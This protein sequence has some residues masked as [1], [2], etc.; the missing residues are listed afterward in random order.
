MTT[1]LV[2]TRVKPTSAGA[3]PTKPPLPLEVVSSAPAPDATDV[4]TDAPISVTF[5]VPLAT[6]TPVPSLSPSVPGSWVQT[7]ADVLAF[8]ASAPLPPGASV[9]LTVPGGSQGVRGARGQLLDQSLTTH[10]TVAPMTML[11]T[12]QLLAQLGYLPLT[13]AP[14]SP[15]TVAAN[16]VA[17]PLVGTFTWR[18]AMPASF[19]SLWSPG[20]ANVVT[21]GAI[22]ALESQRGL[23]TDGVAGPKVWS[24]LLQALAANQ[25]DTDPNYDW[26]DVATSL[27]EHVNVWR[28][29]QIVY[30]TKAN[31]GIEAAPTE[32]GTWPVYARYTS[33]TM[34]GFNPD[35]SHYS[36]PGVPWVSYFH[37]GD[38]LHGFNRSSYGYPQSLGCVEMP[39][40]NAG[41]VYPYTPLGTLVT[42]E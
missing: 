32:Q 28:N 8:D 17:A 37:G 30:T 39:P 36:D 24:A 11:R 21:Q 41:V 14:S 29:G 16:E 20:Q 2:V 40:A 9:A 34:S 25:T 23:T 42:I 7:S 27:P 6:G 12:Q 19:T 10:F 15:A 5:T 13:F 31:T 38:A 4:A 35:G 33:T 1:S 22:M 18:Y 3:A 26:V